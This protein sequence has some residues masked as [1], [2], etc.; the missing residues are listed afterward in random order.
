METDA[1]LANREVLL[2][3]TSWADRNEYALCLPLS[4]SSTERRTM[5]VEVNFI[6]NPEDVLKATTSDR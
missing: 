1:P 4:V 5:N 3:W 6:A 2:V